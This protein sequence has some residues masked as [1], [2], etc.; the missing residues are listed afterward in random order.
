MTC[1]LEW[2]NGT[3]TASDVITVLALD[4]SLDG[5]SWGLMC[6]RP[7][8]VLLKRIWAPQSAAGSGTEHAQD[9]AMMVDTAVQGPCF[10]RQ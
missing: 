6:A 9:L 8:G 10:E 5:A 3:A 1:Y 4:G 7:L 2:P